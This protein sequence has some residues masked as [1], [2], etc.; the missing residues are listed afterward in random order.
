MAVTLVR[1]EEERNGDCRRK[2]R[3]AFVC[4]NT[5]LYIQHGAHELLVDWQNEVLAI[6]MQ[7]F[8]TPMCSSF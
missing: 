1:Q 2:K 8:L 4:L 5:A 6:K 3:Q 7:I